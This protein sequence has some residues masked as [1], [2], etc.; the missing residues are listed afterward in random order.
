MY[1]NWSEATM[2]RIH[3][4]EK[5][6]RDLKKVIHVEKWIMAIIEE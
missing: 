2:S 6:V 3:V 5:E 1:K 4:L